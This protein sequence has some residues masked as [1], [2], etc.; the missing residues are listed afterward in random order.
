MKA[1]KK[2][3]YLCFIALTT[4]ACVKEN[5]DL[6]MEGS[7]ECSYKVTIDGQTTLP[8]QFG[9]DKI[10][11]T[12]SSAEDIFS[13]RITQAKT[14]PSEKS[15]MD[16]VAYN[17]RFNS[18]LPEGAYPVGFFGA[19]SFQANESGLFPLYGF[20]E[21]GEW[22]NATITLVENSDQRI[23]MKVSGTVMKQDEVGGDVKELG[24]VPVEAEIII[25]RKHYVEGTVDGVVV[26]GAVC[27]CQK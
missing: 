8:N 15:V 12:T 11:I 1:I 24:L 27:K 7:A 22:G 26:G 23:R 16:A 20:D 13:F 21:E 3:V 14:D 18:K 6:G 17:G 4:T 2:M 10:V 9:Q 25:G 5:D 19:T